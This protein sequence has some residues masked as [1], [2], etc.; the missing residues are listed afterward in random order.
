MSGHDREELV[1]LLAGEL[2]REQAA[3][4]RARLAREPELAAAWRRLEGAWRDAGP[5]PGAPVP[6]GFA[7]EVMAR[8][9]REAEGA[10]V[11]SWRLAPLWVR[12]A[13]AAA[14]AAGIVAGAGLGT[15]R[16][17]AE[18]PSAATA[19]AAVVETAPAGEEE[20]GFLAPSLAEEYLAAL[21]GEDGEGS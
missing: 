19:A 20:G 4:L 5:V 3:A 14:L 15:L 17:P 8:A 10:P 9:R 16:R 6:P 7:G 18:R 13:G 11:L 1:R 12:A 2:P 21:A